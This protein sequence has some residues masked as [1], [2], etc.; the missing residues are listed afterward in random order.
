[1]PQKISQTAMQDLIGGLTSP[2]T[3][4]S[5]VKSPSPTTTEKPK[6]GRPKRSSDAEQVT[7]FIERSLMD[8]VR[9]LSFQEGF[10][11]KEIFTVGVTQFID[12][13]ERR[14]GKLPIARSKSGGIKE[15]MKK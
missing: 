15:L 6:R 13:F 2:S 7:M 10:S 14:Y 4:S 11:F 1:M 9:A 12:D 8:R 3:S 5:Q